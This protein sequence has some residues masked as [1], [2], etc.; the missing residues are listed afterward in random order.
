MNRLREFAREWRPSAITGGAPI[1]PLLV[2][3]GLN[4]VDELDRTAFAVLTPE[5]RDHFRL[6]IQGILTIVSLTAFLAPF[7][8]ITVAYFA[9][10][11][12]RVRI[13][14]GGAAVWGLFSLMT[15][16]A[17]L[18]W[19]LALSRAF[20]G[21]GRA[22][23][24]P[25]HNSLIADYYDVGVRP[26]V[27]GVHRV[28]NSV[29][30]MVGPI[31]AGLLAVWFHWR[32][33]FVVFAVPTLIFVLL[34]L[35]LRE[36][37]RGAHERRAAG[38]SAESQQI[39]E[40]AP[41]LG[42]AWRILYGVKTLRRIWYAIPFLTAAT[43]GLPFLLSIYYEQN[44]G[45]DEAQRGFIA[46]FAEPV[47]IAALFIGVPIAN[48]LLLRDPGLVL[49][50]VAV[51]GALIS[52]G[53][54][55][56]ASAPNLAT[57]VAANMIISSFAALLVPGIFAILS[58]VI[59]P[60]ARSLGFTIGEIFAILGL[61]SLIIVGAVADEFGV[62]RGLLVLVPVV[63][64]ATGILASAGSFVAADMRKVQTAAA[65]QSNVIAAR[66][67][68]EVKLLL[69]RDLDV[70]YDSV[71]VLFGVDFEVG[72][73]EIV[74]L[75]GTN[76]AGKSTLIR[77][78][79]G[80]V[81][82][83]AGA[84]VFDGRDISYAPPNESAARG[85]IQIPGGKGVFPTLT[86]AENLN[87]AGWLYRRDAK[88]LEAATEQILEN[89]PVLRQRW[90]QRAGD[91]SGGEQQMLTLGMAFI[92]KPRLLM[93]DELTLGLAPVVVERLLE[94]VKAI[95]DQGTTI[96]LVEQSVNLAL[97]IA[98]TAYFM[99]KG[100]IRFHGD[101]SELLGRPDLLRSVFLEGARAGGP[102]RS[103][104]QPR[105][106]ISASRFEEVCSRC[107]RM[108]DVVLE[109][110]EVSLSYGGIRAV[111]DVDLSV[112][113]GE[114]VGIIGP[115]GAGKTSFFDLVS[116]FVT[117]DSGRISVDGRDVTNLGPDARARLG[118][119]RSFQDARLFPSMTV[120]QAIA[121]ALERHVPTPDPIAAA[122]GSPATRTS[123]RKVAERVDELIDLMGLQAYENKFVS[124]LS[125]GTRRV[126]DLACT[127]AHEPK[128]VLFDEPSS[129]I[130]QRETEALGP[131][132]V[133]IRDRTGTALVVIEHD[134][135]LVTSVSD[136]MIALDLGR[137]I[138]TGTP[139]QVVSDP[140]VVESYLGSDIAAI[141]RSGAA[142]TPNGAA[143]ARK[144]GARRTA[145]KVTERKPQRPRR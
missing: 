106:R 17:P 79:S 31:L 37:V 32:V 72:E 142:G 64:V 41:N 75:L 28:A 21:M 143:R 27:Y 140:H 4:A 131:L 63:L 55:L 34:A 134:M 123:E 129:G 107:G 40:D 47:Q 83:Q 56:L 95:R 62:R 6:D 81:D 100:E 51:I 133:N 109:T 112:R 52:G 118:L 80:L 137:V 125:T 68:G 117:P 122:L 113:E 59:P 119:G 73:G 144:T 102:A 74:A 96:I 35:R 20:A 124:E 16:V 105:T 11:T 2:L 15:G 39:E 66:R 141:Q 60:R 29:G 26:K 132:L 48:R 22:V 18:L 135:P 1:Y 114:I 99:E 121:V 44:F 53:W 45:L 50:F 138:A 91:L 86:V 13:A 104:T 10:R 42:E 12:K 108:H 69:V 78:I 87:L 43:L 3:F 82:V 77:A 14:A 84:I 24:T 98:E 61:P 115:N 33:P 58:L 97:T 57:A 85:I 116:G 36:P 70:S 94:S 46:A 67:R 65:A 120:W 23:N 88:H 139:K 89:F 19:M 130:A 25:T 38:A 136:R 90:S 145:A 5:I 127:L 103:G 111:D 9:D 49:R 101:T 76:G 110:N 92:A 30:Q 54:L 128:V 93:I 8:G 71:Q 126:V 7:V